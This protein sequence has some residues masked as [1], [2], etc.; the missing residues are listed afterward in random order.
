MDVCVSVCVDVCV[1]V[2]TCEVCVWMDGMFIAT[3]LHVQ[4]HY[5][6]YRLLFFRSRVARC[7]VLDSAIPRL[8]MTIA[9]LNFCV[10]ACV[11][12]CNNV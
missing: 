3:K 2:C 12:V 4:L 7:S 9:Q 5:I 6:L 10:C 11:R 1:C 8:M